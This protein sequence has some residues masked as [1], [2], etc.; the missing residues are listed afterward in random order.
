MTITSCPAVKA[1]SEEVF[2]SS[3]MLC[4]VLLVMLLIAV[5]SCGLGFMLGRQRSRTLPPPTEA[6]V[7]EV[8]PDI[9]VR[10]ITCQAPTTYCWHYS[11][12]RFKPLNHWEHGAWYEREYYATPG[13][14]GEGQ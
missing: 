9:M 10:D 11:T 3:A 5:L 12:P 6:K 8:V 14:R 13:K 2:G 7:E 1:Q 4:A